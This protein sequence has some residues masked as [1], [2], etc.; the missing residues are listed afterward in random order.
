MTSPELVIWRKYDDVTS[1]VLF[2]IVN[3][4]RRKGAGC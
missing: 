3:L 2:F 4:N 1:G